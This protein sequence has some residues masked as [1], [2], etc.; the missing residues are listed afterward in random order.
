MLIPRRLA[1]I[2]W[3]ESLPS[4]ERLAERLRLELIVVRRKSGDLIDRWRQRWM[5]NVARYARLSTV[6]LIMP[7][8]SAGTPKHLLYE[9]EIPRNIP[10]WEEARQVSEIRQEVAQAARIS[11]DFTEPD[12]IIDR[13][14]ELMRRGNRNSRNRTQ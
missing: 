4:C 13:Y 5:N 11:V 2:E 3:Q 6:K 1:R 7:W 9:E 12:R 8:S 14:H 10:T